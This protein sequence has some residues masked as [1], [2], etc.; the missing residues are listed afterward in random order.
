VVAVTDALLALELDS[1]DDGAT[2]HGADRRVLDHRL[3]LL[4]GEATAEGD[5][6][7]ARLELA[8]LAGPGGNL[9]GVQL[10]HR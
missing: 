5:D 6:R 10:S 3:R 1:Q 7:C 9:G 8:Q 4:L 2:F